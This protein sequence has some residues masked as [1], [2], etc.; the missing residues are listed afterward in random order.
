M[1]AFWPGILDSSLTT[2]PTP[3]SSTSPLCS[4]RHLQVPPCLSLPTACPG[5]LLHMTASRIHPELSWPLLLL[6]QNPPSHSLRGQT[7]HRPPLHDRDGALPCPSG[8]TGG[9]SPPSMLPPSHIFGLC[10]SGCRSVPFRAFCF[11]CWNTPHPA[12]WLLPPPP[13]AGAPTRHFEG[14]CLTAKWPRDP[15][16]TL[17]RSQTQELQESRGPL[18]YANGCLEATG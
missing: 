15:R 1:R 17:L 5:P 8:P 7:R 13:Q 11:L 14:P 9:S 16:H 10:V 18:Q 6:P 12:L 2:P 4:P 3:G